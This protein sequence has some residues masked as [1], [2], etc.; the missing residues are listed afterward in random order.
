MLIVNLLPYYGVQIMA[1]KSR[2]FG[3]LGNQKQRDRLHQKSMQKFQQKLQ[4][5]EWGENFTGIITGP[6]GEVKMSEVLKAFVEPYVDFAR[7]RVQRE[8]LISIAV[9]AWN[10]SLMPEDKRQTALDQSIEAGLE[11]NDPLVKQDIREM[12]DDLIARKLKLF[13]KNKRFIVDFQLQDT[14]K[15][16]HLSVASTLENPIP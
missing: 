8:R 3:E 7:N 10:L 1:K 6:K 12:I 9:I 5:G 14:G 11:G 16:F 2:G 15:A 13:A 4:K